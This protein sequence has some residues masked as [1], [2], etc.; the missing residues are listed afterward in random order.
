MNQTR[1]RLFGDALY[2]LARLTR[3]TARYRIAGRE[4]LAAC[5]AAGRPV[6]W[7]A[8]HGMTM[9]LVGYFLREFDP[10]RL[11]II[12]PDDW[13]GESLERFTRRLGA[14]PFPMNVKD[15]ASMATARQLVRLTRLTR[16]GHDSYMT[17][18]GPDGPAYR[19][20]PGVAFL[21]QKSDA[22]LLPVGAYTRTGYRLPRWDRYVVPRPFSRIDV[23][24]GPPVP[25]PA[26]APLEAILSQLTDALHRVTAQAAANYYEQPIG[27]GAG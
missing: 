23:V 25:T 14:R 19:P 21:A 7:S 11:L 27:E 15:A 16:A 1:N 8:W 9:M 6:V 12:L 5:R 20:K 13:R 22:A 2:A 24:I 3:G 18:D 10:S 26:G 4:Y 17:P